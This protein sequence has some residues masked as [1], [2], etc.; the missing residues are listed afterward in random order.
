MIPKTK[1]FDGCAVEKRR[2]GK[3]EEGKEG[4]EGKSY[5]ALANRTPSML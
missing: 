3:R 5:S 2:T 4:K 1:N